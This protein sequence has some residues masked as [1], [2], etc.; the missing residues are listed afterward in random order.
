MMYDRTSKE[1]YIATRERPAKDICAKKD[2]P[3][4]QIFQ[5]KFKNYSQNKWEKE[6][7]ENPLLLVFQKQVNFFQAFSPG[8]QMAIKNDLKLKKKI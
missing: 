1:F 7:K 2:L 5:W 4:R 6:E 8:T 3:K